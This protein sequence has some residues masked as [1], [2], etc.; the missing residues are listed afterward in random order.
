MIIQGTWF[1]DTIS[2][3]VGCQRRQQFTEAYIFFFHMK[4]PAALPT[5][6]PDNMMAF[7]VTLFVCPTVVCDT[8][9]KANTMPAASVPD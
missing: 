7:V 1:L 3:V 8:Q 9:I 5:Q 6:Y 2:V 4:G